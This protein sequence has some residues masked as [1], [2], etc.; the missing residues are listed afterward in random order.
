[1][2]RKCWFAPRGTVAGVLLAVGVV[3]TSS[4]GF[5]AQVC[6]LMDNSGDQVAGMQI[7][8]AWDGTCMSGAQGAG[9]S[10][11]CTANASTGKNANSSFTGPSGMRVLFFAMDNVDP[12]PDG[13]LFC[14]NFTA[15][16]RPCCGLQIGHL[17]ASDATGHRLNDPNVAFLATVDG[18]GCAQLAA[19]SD[20]AAGGGPARGPLP[21]QQQQPGAVTAEGGNVGGDTGVGAPGGAA[22]SA[23]QPQSG[24]AQQQAGSASKPGAGGPIGLAPSQQPQGP[25]AAPGAL[26][27]QGGTGQV[28]GSSAQQGAT[29]QAPGAVGAQAGSQAAP[30]QL[31]AGA[32]APQ[33]TA[34][35][36]GASVGTPTE[37]AA[38]PTS[39]K[40]AATK[41]PTKA[42]PTATPT[43]GGFLSGCQMR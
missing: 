33:A 42:L 31:A 8:L 28:P 11:Q 1:M 41:T 7:D 29:G 32:A 17:I 10:A 19:T 12:I 26:A 36:T 9:K 27:Q 5:A 34:A 35:P 39:T 38:A 24:Q 25:E 13:E 20:S 6:V 3:G 37:V 22:P 30:G 16:A 21:Q 40:V 15:P 23:P 43:S 14:C 18:Q 2:Q 4:V